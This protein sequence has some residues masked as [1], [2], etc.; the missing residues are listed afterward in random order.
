MHNK[1]FTLDSEQETLTNQLQQI[2]F[3]EINKN[4]NYISFSRYME[5]ALYHPSLGYY[6]NLLYKFG[7]HGDFVTAPLI[8]E[9]FGT[10]V[11]HQILELFN[12]QVNP[13]ILEVGSGNGQLMLDILSQI[14]DKLTH[15][16]ILELSANLAN[17]QQQ[18]LEQ[19]L[20][21]YKDKVIWLTDLPLDFKGVILANEV[22]DAQPCE[23]VHWQP[24]QVS[25]R[26][27]T[28]QGG[29]F[30]YVDIKAS[31]EVLDIANSLATNQA[32]YISEISLINRGFICSLAECLASGV[33]LLIDYGYTAHEYYSEMRNRGTLRGFFR[34]HQLDDVLIYPGLIDITA[35]VDFTAIATSGIGSGLDL[36]GYTKQANF[37]IN[38]GI[39][40]QLEN[41]KQQLNDLE[42][43]KMSNQ[44]NRLISPNEMG[45]AFKVLAFSKNI[46][47]A[48]FIGFSQGD[49]SHTL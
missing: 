2:V 4:N 47:F 1:L 30:S 38:C 12:H 6:N 23:V 3:A 45:E 17:L 34:Q 24:N 7:K 32:D 15:Y 39:V 19:E 27:V 16:Y 14:G 10:C 8:S 49:K 44:V 25:L 31:G 40:S 46:E 48:D 35:S 18:R 22:L 29:K 13:N 26:G 5:L 42:Y 33:I 11:S 9:L 21:Q 41:K 37:L 36:I 20:P 28:N 43:L